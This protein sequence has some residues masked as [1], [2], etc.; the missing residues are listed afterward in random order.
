MHLRTKKRQTLAATL[1]AFCVTFAAVSSAVV[2]YVED[3]SGGAPGT[4]NGRSGTF[5]YAGYS[6]SDSYEGSFAAQGIPSPQTDAIRITD[7]NFLLNYATAYN[8]YNDFWWTF[9][10]TAANVAPSDINIII[11]SASDTFYYT[12]SLTARAGLNHLSVS[13]DSSKW[14]GGPGVYS[15]FDLSG[16]TYI[17]IQYSRNGTGAQQYYLDNFALNGKATQQGGDDDE[18]GGGGGGA[19]PEPNTFFVTAL[20]GAALFALRRRLVARN[21]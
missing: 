14:I 11:G 8:L 5:S 20:A 19:V 2:I 12:G 3:F 7:S 17:D 15:T 18:G 10:F 4:Y 6:G 16:I 1:I 13:L 21:V 9:D